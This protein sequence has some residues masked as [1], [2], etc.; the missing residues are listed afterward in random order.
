[1]KKIEVKLPFMIHRD[2]K[3]IESEISNLRAG[4]E[5]IAANIVELTNA[6]EKWLG[7]RMGHNW[8]VW[9]A[10]ADEHE[11]DLLEQYRT[12]NNIPVSV[13]TEKIAEVY[14][15]PDYSHILPIAR[16]LSKHDKEYLLEMLNGES[17]VAPEV[18]KSEKEAIVEKHTTYIITEGTLT[19][20]LA[21]CSLCDYANTVNLKVAGRQKITMGALIPAMPTEQKK[22]VEWQFDDVA[23]MKVFAPKYEHFKN[24]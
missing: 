5:G 8:S 14:K 22:L 17:V 11:N 1:M 2:E 3:A 10:W 20:Y 21:I 24:K 9:F 13:R 16:G 4:Y 15:V 18:T 23:G 6:L 19:L 12:A 7:K